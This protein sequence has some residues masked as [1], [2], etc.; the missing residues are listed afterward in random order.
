V[1]LRALGKELES[2][3]PEAARRIAYECERIEASAAEFARIRA[4]H[5]IASGL[6][7]L[8]DD[9]QADLTRLLLG[10]T[11]SQALG[12]SADGVR[13]AALDGVTRWRTRAE[14]PFADPT[15]REACEAGARTCEV[16]YAGTGS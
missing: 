14:D 2:G 11:A 9:E 16:F 13:T 1:A 10:T 12:V 6:V 7:E 5:L 8:R 15:T 4:A 3:A